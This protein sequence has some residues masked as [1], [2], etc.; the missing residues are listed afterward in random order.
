MDYI[1]SIKTDWGTVGLRG[2]GYSDFL[3]WPRVGKTGIT[4]KTKKLS[5]TSENR[6]QKL[7]KFK[8]FNFFLEKARTKN[9]R[10]SG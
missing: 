8:Y 4:G 7:C 3:K 6:K 10:N 1:S 5:G 9:L 2:K